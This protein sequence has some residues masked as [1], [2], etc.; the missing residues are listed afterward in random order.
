MPTEPKIHTFACP[1]A[2]IAAYIDGELDAGGEFDLERHLAGCDA[3]SLELNSQKH[4]LRNLDIS[5]RNEREMDL[6]AN[7]TRLIV[8][9]AESTVSGLR[10]PR[11]RFNALFICAGL[12]LFVL[13]AMG[14]E[15]ASLFDGLA[16]AVEKTFAV[17]D[18]FARLIYSIFVGAAIIVRAFASQFQVG[19]TAILALAMIFAV[20]SLLMSQKVARTHRA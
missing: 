17:G 5:F 11:E 19:V 15:A 6:P 7:F 9:N 2:E 3:C 20:F 16:G 8:A 1:S 4:F 14:A 10:R 18:I 13:F 12:L